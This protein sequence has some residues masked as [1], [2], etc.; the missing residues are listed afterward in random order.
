MVRDALRAHSRTSGLPARIGG[1]RARDDGDR[2][3]N[4]CDRDR[5]R[6]RSQ[7]VVCDQPDAE[8]DTYALEQGGLAMRRLL[9]ALW[10]WM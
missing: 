5:F 9:G 7:R 4:V 10:A 2:P 1:E 8:A 3:R 6:R